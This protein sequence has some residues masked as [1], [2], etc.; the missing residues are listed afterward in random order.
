[1]FLEALVNAWLV[2]LL[3]TLGLLEFALPRRAPTQGRGLRWPTNLTIG[4]LNIVFMGVAIAPVAAV[5]GD[6]RWGLLNQ[7]SVSG[8]PAVVIAVVVRQE[9][10]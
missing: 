2:A 5:A 9:V 1:M 8:V 10:L 4:S 6:L 3:A 7:L